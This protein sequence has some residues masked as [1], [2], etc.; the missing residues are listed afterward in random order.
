MVRNLEI[1]WELPSSGCSQQGGCRL[2]PFTL[3][4]AV[5]VQWIGEGR[6]MVRDV[7]R[8]GVTGVRL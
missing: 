4:V 8:L 7:G 1:F 3:E 2:L 6:V 5:E